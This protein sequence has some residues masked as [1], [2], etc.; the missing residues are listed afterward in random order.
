M[1]EEQELDS[2]E[3]EVLDSQIVMVEEDMC[4]QVVDKMEDKQAVDTILEGH[5][6][7]EVEVDTEPGR[8]GRIGRREE[9]KLEEAD[10][11]F[12]ES[13]GQGEEEEE[14]ALEDHSLSSQEEDN[15][16]GMI[17]LEAGTKGE[18]A[19]VRKRLEVAP[20]LVEDRDHLDPKHLQEEG[21]KMMV[22]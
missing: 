8:I 5:M 6:K 3:A 9:Q 19:V 22:G 13:E 20:V 15:E 4:G 18:E 1:E 10:R 14:Q 21:G 7:M 12:L 16:V 17:V 2:L 11:N